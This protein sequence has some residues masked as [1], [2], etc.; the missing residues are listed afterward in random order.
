MTAENKFTEKEARVLDLLHQ[1]QEV[2]KMIDLH[3]GEGG[4]AFMIEQYVDVKKGF[5]QE[6]KA[7]LSDFEIEVL[8][9]KQDRAA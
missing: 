4:D 5:L 1:I 3:K 7:I 2:N 6:L 9:P 8:I